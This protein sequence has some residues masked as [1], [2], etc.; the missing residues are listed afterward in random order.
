MDNKNLLDKQ[1]AMLQHLCHLPKKILQL[2]GVPNSSE[3]VLHDLCHEN[4]FGVKKAAYFVDNPDFNC[5]KGIAGF[6]KPEA[7]VPKMSIWDEIE[8]FSNHM[9]LSS[10]NQKVRNLELQSIKNS[11]RP[12]QDIV[13]E[14]AYGLDFN[15]YSYC[16]WHSKHD[17]HGFLVYEKPQD[18]NET[19]FLEGGCLLGLCPIV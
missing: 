1:H 10:F 5:V 18:K 9:K 19:Y 7:Y 8:Q 11:H 14:I 4:C 13:H 15:D 6:H 12:D 3:F 2:H 17:N 16:T